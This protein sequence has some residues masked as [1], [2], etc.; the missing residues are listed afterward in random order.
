[1]AETRDRVHVQQRKW[2]FCHQ[3]TLIDSESIDPDY[4]VFL[5]LRVGNKK[6]KINQLIILSDRC[7]SI[8][9]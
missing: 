1:M 9:I 4:I 6:K 8:I 2:E 7:V 3:W 5:Y